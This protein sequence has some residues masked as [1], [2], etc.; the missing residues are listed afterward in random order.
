MSENG[1]PKPTLQELLA[2]TRCKHCGETFTSV[3][4]PII[5]QEQK[6]FMN[7]MGKL[8]AHLQKKHPEV[9]AQMFALQAEF[10]GMLMLNQFTTMDEQLNREQDL[11]RHKIFKLCQRVQVS[12]AT[13]EQRV[14]DL[15]VR[16]NLCEQTVVELLKQSRDVLGE[17]GLYP[18]A[19]PIITPGPQMPV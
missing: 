9:A 15:C 4:V 13:I 11:K 6:Q 12:N 16:D 5:G 3:R 10:S 17:V 7:F 18:E 8:I 14:R 19:S 1:K 2:D